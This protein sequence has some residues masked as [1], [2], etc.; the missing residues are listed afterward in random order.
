M[1]L[2]ENLEIA[3]KVEPQPFGR[4]AIEFDG[5]TGIATT[6]GLKSTANF[7][8]FLA[9]AGYDPELYEVVGTPRTSRW[10]QREGGEWLTAYRFT[11]RLRN[12]SIDL[13]LLWATA[14]KGINRTT[15]KSTNN[16]T[17]VILWSDLQLGK[18]D[19]RGNSE[20]LFKRVE[21][22][23]QKLIA[24]VK[25][26]KPNQ[27]IF[28]DVGDIV[29]NFT[30]A[31]DLAQLQSN[32]LSIQQQIDIATTI[33]WDVLKRLTPHTERITYASVGSNHCQMRVNKQRVFKPV[34]DWGI[35][36]GRTLARLAHETNLP[37]KFIEPQPHD[38][39]LAYDVFG[40]GFH[41]LG[42][43][44]G[45]Q[46]A[47]PDGVPDWWRKQA[48]GRQPVADATVGVSGH[49]HHLQV[50]ELGSTNKGHSRYWIQA[51]TLDNG[52]SW[53]RLNAGEDSQPGLVCFELHKDQPFTGTVFKL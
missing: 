20:A 12:A 21:E 13:P 51:S 40:D 10:Q 5:I 39:S 16:Q 3:S 34:D 18:V 37:I 25:K 36:I 30:N 43:W 7:D 6:P 8:E 14:R 47:R 44:H 9:E 50:R 31:A 46:A 28:C 42:L 22:T 17:L 19:S 48:F 27:I 53:Y 29:E 11:F 26:D 35:H 32:D 15:P 49:F 33:V 23:V 2:L 45:H 1:Q 41:I 52:S 38:E 4:P 24:K